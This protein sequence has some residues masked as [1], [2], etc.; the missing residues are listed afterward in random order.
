[1]PQPGM[2]GRSY[3]WFN[4]ASQLIVFTQVKK[5]S[6]ESLLLLGVGHDET[7]WWG[8]EGQQK[9]EPPH[10]LRTLSILQLRLCG[11]NLISDK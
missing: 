6:K 3:E 2:L 9:P 7:N 4:R 11:N 8:S 10:Y 1:M 5:R